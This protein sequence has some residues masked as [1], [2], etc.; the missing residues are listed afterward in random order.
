MYLIGKSN[1]L[2]SDKA[3]RPQSRHFSLFGSNTLTHFDMH[4]FFSTLTYK[5]L[6]R[7][8]VDRHVVTYITTSK[9]IKYS[10]MQKH[11]C[12]CKYELEGPCLN[13]F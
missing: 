13:Y 11:V 2:I 1:M 8:C 6:C 12:T 7:A 9:Y 5:T 10:D 4:I 3:D